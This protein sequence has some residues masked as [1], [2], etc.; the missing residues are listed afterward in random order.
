MN[1]LTVK[2]SFLALVFSVP[3]VFLDCQTTRALAGDASPVCYSSIAS[4][5]VGFC[6]PIVTESDI[7]YDNRYTDQSYH[8]I[9]TKRT[10]EAFFRD[11]K[12]VIRDKKLAWI[13]LGDSLALLFHSAFSFIRT[14]LNGLPL[15]IRNILTDAK[16]DY[17]FLIYDVRLTHTQLVGTTGAADS[18]HTASYG[19]GIYRKLAYKCSI[20]NV[21]K[22]KSVYFKE[23]NREETGTSLDLVEKSIRTLFREMIKE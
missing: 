16:I 23:V 7:F 1:S 10:E 8:S 6:S 19:S 17:A 12:H 5:T 9:D 13:E 11:L 4:G 14:P 15:Q 21:A 18:T 20:V 3:A 22:N 2:L